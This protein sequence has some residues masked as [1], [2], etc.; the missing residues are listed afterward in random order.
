MSTGE[1]LHTLENATSSDVIYSGD[2]S[3]VLIGG[4][5]SDQVLLW[6]LETNTA[7]G[8]L[9]M[10]APPVISMA[11]SPD[12]RYFAVEET[13]RSID[14]LTKDGEIIRV[15]DNLSDTPMSEMMFSAGLGTPDRYHNVLFGRFDRVGCRNG[16]TGN[17]HAQL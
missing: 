10:E 15:L 16:R 17:S 14:L 11:A 4:G 9:L 13:D 6:N 3:R 1:V 5:E 7:V 8:V 2:G 12:G